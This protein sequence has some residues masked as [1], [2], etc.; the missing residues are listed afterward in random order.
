MEN[1]NVTGKGVKPITILVDEE[2][3]EHREVL[4][5]V[6]GDENSNKEIQS[7]FKEIK[8]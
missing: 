8:E 4:N 6:D 2:T 5:D 1:L 3:T 7:M